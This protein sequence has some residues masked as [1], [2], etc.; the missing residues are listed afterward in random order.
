ML[1]IPLVRPDCKGNM[2]K[3][4]VAPGE[5]LCYNIVHYTE[6]EAKRH[7]GHF[8]GQELHAARAA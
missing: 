2:Q 1:I 3:A 5:H 7:V 8:I 6:G 4:A